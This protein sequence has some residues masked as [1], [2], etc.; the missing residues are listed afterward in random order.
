MCITSNSAISG[1]VFP[2]FPHALLWL[3][4]AGRSALLAQP[5]A[6]QP[7][8]TIAAAPKHEAAKGETYALLIGI[9][10]YQH[11]NS[12]QFADKDA[13]L[14]NSF[15]RSPLGGVD[16]A[17]IVLLEN[18]GA[19]RAAIDVALKGFVKDHAAA[20]NS[21]IV[22]V[23]GHGVDLTTE[24]DP[25]TKKTIERAPYIVT[26]DSNTAD[27]KTTGY[28]MDEFRSAV[29]QQA[30]YYGRVMV[31]VDVCH[32]ANI[33]GIGGGSELQ[34]E[35]GKVFRGEAGLFDLMVASYGN[36]YAF[37][38]P[39]FG[40]GHGAFSYFLVSGLNGAAAFPGADAIHWNELVHYVSDGVFKYTSGQQSPQNSASKG[41]ERLVVVPDIHQQGIVLLGADVISKSQLRDPRIF[42]Q[43][44]V[45]PPSPS[46]PINRN[47]DEIAEAIALGAL[48]PEDPGS[49]SLLIAR[50]TP[51]TRERIDGERRL[52]VALEDEGQQ[53]VSQYLEGDQIPQHGAEFTHCARL[54]EE[55]AQLTSPAD[56]DR[57]RALFCRGRALI[58]EGRYNEADTQLRQSI[59]L[60]PRRAYAWNALGISRLEQIAHLP[61][62][63]AAAAFDEAATDFLTAMRYAP[64]WAYPVHN[65]SLT[66]SERGD[67]DGAIRLYRF[68]MQIAPQYSYLPYNL[69]L[70]YA[71]LGDNAN[72]RKWFEA[73]GKVAV[74]YPRKQNG[75]WPERAQILNAL[76]TLA[77]E[78]HDAT[79]ART[80]FNS[81]MADDPANP[82]PRQNLALLAAGEKNYPEADRLWTAVIAD[83]PAFLAARVS[84]AA[85][86]AE[87]KDNARAIEQYRQILRIDPDWTG[88]H[89]ALARL[90]LETGD[91]A[92]AL[93]ELDA[94]LLATPSNP[95]LLEMRGDLLSRLG[96]APE[97]AADW[98]A[99]LKGA[100]TREAAGR[101]A[102]KLKE[103]RR[104]A[105]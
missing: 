34:A 62:N 50:L 29:A 96:R 2:R 30:L 101:L 43:P 103:E 97:A 46:G 70:L 17:N 99:A 31:Y 36:E 93:R 22:F 48:L 59:Q 32:A 69:G 73:A 87:R 49:A 24:Q 35:V 27:A 75:V 4:L 51:G 21:L 10:A 68:A 20:E 100:A 55:A 66:L 84:L 60:D 80:L 41:A 72:A 81:A 1:C 57:S 42:R 25:V 58:F 12:L 23:A 74:A 53:I 26:Y 19:T 86:L 13:E 65:L 5:P 98:N 61:S 77:V 8:G 105:P 79:R 102:R 54:F 83:S 56:F 45:Q 33:A 44:V 94:G 28:P 16:K 92:E 104:K 88:V 3:A 18:A 95:F 37:E 90:D 6:E 39:S 7:R 47:T 78:R 40:G 67:F 14:L 9:S 38:S 85:S 64:Y 52:R 63:P 15:L 91:T 11:V 71:R 76:G 82:N 89:E